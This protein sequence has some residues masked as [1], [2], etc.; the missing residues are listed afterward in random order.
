MSV[1]VSSYGV[2]GGCPDA[3]SLTLEQSCVA[4]VSTFCC[5]NSEEIVR[6]F[7]PSLQQGGG[8]SILETSKVMCGRCLEGV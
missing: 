5:A 7:V 4:L 1:A 8:K 2:S 3:L 6:A